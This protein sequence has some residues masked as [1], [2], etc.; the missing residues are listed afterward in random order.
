MLTG[1]DHVIVAVADLE[2]A[3]QAVTD[4][5]G[6]TVAPGGSH[7]GFGT[8]NRL[9]W[10]G[11]AYLELV[12]VEDPAAAAASWFGAAILAVLADADG[13]G[14]RGVPV[15]LALASDDIGGDAAALGLAEPSAGQRTRPDGGIVGWRMARARDRTASLSPRA[16]V[17]WPLVF[18]I[19]HDLAGAE[20]TPSE[21]A[22]RAA[23]VHPLGTPVQIRSVT[24]GMPSVPGAVGRLSREFRLAFRPSLVGGGARDAAIGGHTLR[25]APE[26]A[27]QPR[28]TI[29]LRGGSE[30]RQLDLLGCRWRLAPILDKPP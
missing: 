30:P 16:A 19:Q 9:A 6:L 11:D 22:P 13:T 29:E 3:A 2:A 25:L 21:R 8:R 4:E 24:F 1:I 26:R 20:W 12:A 7:P 23:A 27:G 10:W 5:L 28:V 18:L 17:G 14:S 15:G